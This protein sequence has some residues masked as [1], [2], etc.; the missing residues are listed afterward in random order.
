MVTNC[1]SS[2]HKQEDTD[3]AIYRTVSL[4]FWTDPKVDD[5]FS[6]EDKYFYLYL[7]TNPHTTISGCYE[8][9]MKQMCRETGYN[10]D[11]VNRLLNRLEKQH[12]VIRYSAQFKEVLIMNWH[13]YNWSKSEKVIAGVIE[14]ASHVKD[15]QHRAYLAVLIQSYGGSTDTLSIGY[16]YPMETSVSVSVTDTVSV[17]KTDTDTVEVNNTIPLVHVSEEQ[18]DQKQKRNGK[19]ENSKSKK[20]TE[21]VP[22]TLEEVTEYCKSR[23]SIVDPKAFFD[24]FN[25]GKWIDSRGNPVLNWKQKIITWE[26]KNI[27]KAPEGVRNSGLSGASPSGDQRTNRLPHIEGRK[28]D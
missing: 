23:Q 22:P 15:P 25:E 17:N 13:K 21:F 11:T 18:K 12:E 2:N 3:V 26:N 5:E 7:L 20:K 19:K 24:F 4:N 27:S 1:H 10:E 9:S 14:Q 28:L 6:P 16:Q 8:I